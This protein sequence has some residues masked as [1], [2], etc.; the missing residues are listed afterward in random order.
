MFAGTRWWCRR[1]GNTLE[2]DR[3]CG[4]GNRP[5]SQAASARLK[6]DKLH[7]WRRSCEKAGLLGG[8]LLDISTYA[9]RASLLALERV[10]HWVATLRLMLLGSPAADPAQRHKTLPKPLHRRRARH[11]DVY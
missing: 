5:S 6:M 1:E 3:H 7:E 10:G 8:D 4:Q 2:T 9:M 11:Q